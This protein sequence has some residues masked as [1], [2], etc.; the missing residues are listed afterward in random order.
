MLNCSYLCRCRARRQSASKLHFSIFLRSRW[1]TSRQETQ[2]IFKCW[3]FL[4]QQQFDRSTRCHVN[5][6]KSLSRKKRSGSMA[7]VKSRGRRQRWTRSVHPCCHQRNASV[8]RAV[9][10]SVYV[11]DKKVPLAAQQWSLISAP[12]LAVKSISGI[13][14]LLNVHLHELVL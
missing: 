6:R 3:K 8:F 12:T 7:E 2:S 9:G 14:L 13:R 5:R 4:H 11:A 10:G 1:A